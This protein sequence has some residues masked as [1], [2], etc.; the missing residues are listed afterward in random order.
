MG[1]IVLKACKVK[2]YIQEDLLF[3]VEIH[4]CT[5]AGKTDSGNRA[6][7]WYIFAYVLTHAFRKRFYLTGAHFT[8]LGIFCGGPTDSW[9]NIVTYLSPKIYL[10]I[11]END[12][13]LSW[14]FLCDIPPTSSAPLN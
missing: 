11:V 5:A 12:D 13:F 2:Q 9:Q 8:F 14:P 3:K 4:I 10:A 7:I 1:T 6:L